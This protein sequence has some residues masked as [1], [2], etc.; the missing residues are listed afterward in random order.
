M[1]LNVLEVKI[2][3]IIYI[4]KA[5]RISGS[6]WRRFGYIWHRFANWQYKCHPVLINL[7]ICYWLNTIKWV[8]EIE[9]LVRGR[10]L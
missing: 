8:K 1:Y 7:Y 6:R 10:G 9:K 5:W 4:F 2:E 3:A